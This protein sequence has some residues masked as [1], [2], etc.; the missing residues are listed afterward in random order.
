MANQLTTLDREY[1]TSSKRATAVPFHIR[2]FYQ[3]ARNGTAAQNGLMVVHPKHCRGGTDMRE[4]SPHRYHCSLVKVFLAAVCAWS[5]FAL[6]SFNRMVSLPGRK[7]VAESAKIGLSHDS[8]ARKGDRDEEAAAAAEEEKENEEEEVEVEEEEEDKDEEDDNE[9]EKEEGEGE[10]QAVKPIRPSSPS[11]R[12][13][14]F[15]LIRGGAER[16]NYELFTRRCQCL[17]SNFETTDAYDE[18]VQE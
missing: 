8:P 12:S 6:A 16:Q 11:V 2:I 15:T 4:K 1:C 10:L 14:V 9:D 3:A 5:F 7:E 18:C 13:V 17:S